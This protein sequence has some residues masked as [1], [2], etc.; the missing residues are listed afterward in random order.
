MRRQSTTPTD[1]PR[2]SLSLQSKIL[3]LVLTPLLITTIGLVGAE[4]FERTQD[5]RTQLQQ[6]RQ[7]LLESREQGVQNVVELAT[8]TITPLVEESTANDYQQRTED[9]LRSE[10]RQRL[11]E[12]RFEGDNYI[13]MFDT[14]GTMLVQSAVPEQEG[15]PML[16]AQDAEGRPF[17]RGMIELAQDGG[18]IYQYHWPNPATG[19]TE[20]KYS[21]VSLVPE[22]NWVIGAGVYVTEI[23][24]A[25][26][27]I[28]AAAARDLR[29]TLTKII[30]ASFL[31]FLAIAT[32]TVWI[33]RRM[34]GNIRNTAQAMEAIAQEVASGKGD[35]T[36]QIAVTSGDEIGNLARQFNAFM[37]RIQ[38]TLLEVRNGA[39]NVYHAS[40][41]FAQSSE[42][43][44]SRTDQ[45]AANLQQTSSAM[46]QITAAVN[47]SAEHAQQA[48]N[49]A[50]STATVAHRGDKAMQ[51]V[52]QT[53]NDIDASS[54]RIGDIISMIDSI[55][56]QTNILALNASVEAARAGEHGRGFAV[57][58]QEVRLLAS[59]S[60]DAAK[61]IRGL[62]DT[63]V[64][65]SQNG[66]LLVK[67][68]GDTMQEIV[69]SVTKVAD[70]IAEITAGAQEQSAGIHEVNTAVS[71][72]DTM[73]QQNAS[74]VAQSTGTAADMRHQAQSLSQLIGSFVLDDSPCQNWEAL[75]VPNHASRPSQ[76]AP[77]LE[78]R[79]SRKEQFTMSSNATEDTWETF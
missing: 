48:N 39:Q 1:E 38:E 66:K 52:A 29:Q 78:S 40:N 13:F 27:A 50:T 62:I 55:A 75:A 47:Q 76:A 72:M 4:T 7:M 57:V 71:E 28:E 49:L 69:S 22:W 6:Q 51:D 3:L 63:S 23:D 16:N 17:I 24:T 36:Q 18:G 74:M 43:L 12:L 79:S 31:L 65:H 5:N 20:T 35:L 26:A 53:M 30:G 33:T 9:H 59:R 54:M 11:R 25:M 64:G 44:A 8:S 32:I 73:T 41:E 15:Q 68:A 67:Q 58:A 45:A 14:E 56:F 10:A 61:E 46:E 60:S 42:E 34:V 37:S 19:E 70:V 21:Y 2:K 77:Q